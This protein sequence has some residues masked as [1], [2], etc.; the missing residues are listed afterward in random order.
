MSITS[1][2]Y[3]SC[4]WERILK[5]YSQQ[6]LIIRYSVINYSHHERTLFLNAQATPVNLPKPRALGNSHQLYFTP[7]W[8]LLIFPSSKSLQLFMHSWPSLRKSTLRKMGVGRTRA[9]FP[10]NPEVPI[11]A[12]PIDAAFLLP[13]FSKAIQSKTIQ[14]WSQSR[15]FGVTSIRRLTSLCW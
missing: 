12:N 13:I 10:H 9:F 4:V 8:L 14:G 11:D 15:L 3:P 5:F 2:V 1:H 7:Y 6:I